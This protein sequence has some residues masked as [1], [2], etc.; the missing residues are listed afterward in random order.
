M[1]LLNVKGTDCL[2]NGN[3]GH[4]TAKI[5]LAEVI[6]PKADDVSS[7]YIFFKYKH[8]DSSSTTTGGLQAPMGSLLSSG[9]LSDPTAPNGF[10]TTRDPMRAFRTFGRE[11]VIF[12][13]SKIA[14]ADDISSLVWHR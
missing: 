3:K 6:S 1:E 8:S 12:Y 7:H 5:L 14:R 4:R 2:T 10:S 13:F 11:L 9:T